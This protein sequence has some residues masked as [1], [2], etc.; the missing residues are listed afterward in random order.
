[1]SKRKEHHVPKAVKAVV[2]KTPDAAWQPPVCAGCGQTFDNHPGVQSLCKR[3][4]V[5]EM[6]VARA[7]VRYQA[8]GSAAEM[9]SILDEWGK[10]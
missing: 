2:L 3:V 1:M 6:L 9:Y 7:K 4:L 8:R 10:R 5:L